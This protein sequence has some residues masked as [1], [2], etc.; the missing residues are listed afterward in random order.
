MTTTR[1]SECVLYIDEF[2]DLSIGR[3]FSTSTRAR[4]IVVT[5]AT[6]EYGLRLLH[7]TG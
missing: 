7:G 2:S 1:R 5:K 6:S 4:A 3:T